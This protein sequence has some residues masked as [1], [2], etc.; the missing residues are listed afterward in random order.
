M[1]IF[2][3]VKCMSKADKKIHFSDFVR[4]AALFRYMVLL[5][6]IFLS[7][8]R[9]IKCMSLHYCDFKATSKT[10][11]YRKCPIDREFSRL[12]MH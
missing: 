12:W 11:I 8:S 7:L 10:L 5:E 9:S 4:I 2:Y 1:L 6:F 3:A